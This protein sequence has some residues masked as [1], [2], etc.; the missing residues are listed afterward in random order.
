M[1]GITAGNSDQ[2]R[3]IIDKE[4][5]PVLVKLLLI[6]RHTELLEHVRNII[7]EVMNIV[8]RI[9]NYKYRI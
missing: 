9:G 6:S 8:G 1:C 7:L 2:I 3:E 5:V 4:A